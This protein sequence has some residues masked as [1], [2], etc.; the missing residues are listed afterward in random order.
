MVLGH[1]VLPTLVACQYPPK[2]GS[3]RQPSFPWAGR[4]VTTQQGRVDKAVSF[5]SQQRG[6]CDHLRLQ[7]R[8]GGKI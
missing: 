8:E 7:K 3:N 6:T 5:W 1:T 2:W 4:Q